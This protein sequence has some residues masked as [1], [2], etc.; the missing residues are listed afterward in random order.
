MNTHEIDHNSAETWDTLWEAEGY[1]SWR[2]E[3]LKEVYE[4]IGQL[5]P[6]HSKVIDIGG[7]IGI[8][9]RRLQE[10]GHSVEIWDRS[11][12][13][14]EMAQQ[15]GLQ[16]RVVDI[17]PDLPEI[18]PGTIVVATE[19]LEHLPESTRS[20]LLQKISGAG[21]KGLFSVPNNRLGPDE[22]PQHTI[23]YSAK[24]FRD[25][26]LKYFGGV[27]VEC[28]GTNFLL[29]VCG[30]KKAGTLSMCLPVRDEAGDL[31]VVLASF[32]GACDEIVV[33][34]DP[35]TKDRTRE[36]A[37][38]YAD[39]VFELENPEGPADQKMPNGG[40]H[41]AWIRNQCL[42]RCT[43][44]WI[45]MTEGHE[46]LAE[47]QDTLLALD[48]VPEHVKLA[49]VMR[50]ARGPV[51]RQE[52]L[53]PW[54]TRRTAGLRYKRHTHNILDI[55]DGTP[56]IFLPKVRT[57]HFRVHAREVARA[58][59]R[60]VQ[61]R[62]ELMRDWVIDE[63]VNSLYY[64]A[65]EWRDFDNSKS[66]DLFRELLVRDRKNGGRRYQ[67]GLILAKLLTERGDLKEARETLLECTGHDWN[68][69]EHWVFLGDLA[70][71]EE[72]YEE[73]KQFYLYAS[74]RIG[75]RPLTL[76]WIELSFY[77]FVPAQRLAMTCACLEQYEESL[78]WA[79][80]VLELLPEEAPEEM[81]GEAR[82]NIE[83]IRKFMEEE[84][85]AF[86]S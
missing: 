74:T 12:K 57:D 44:D 15:H 23:K 34:V 28:F 29:G 22:E 58:A 20:L 67:A 52:W 31:E 4:R 79:E 37:S 33:G 66:I 77:S 25:N 36:I 53:F 68:R 72:R 81:F 13:A 45:F 82:A 19:F 26:L 56:E 49:F 83:H 43:S 32:R 7:G 42:E 30:W 80:R 46:S 55:P 86:A 8:L 16:G 18:E 9:A 35:R 60:K 62:L 75:R 27:R 73:A 21:A 59:Q 70:F 65:S 64:L 5:L 78:G 10:L 50:S 6:T 39:V 1:N 51:G 24:S 84:G 3:V 40:V 63:N 2:G 76:W 48:Q 54:L 69:T 17:G 41:F 61:N 11:P 14:I 38:L 47:G 71:E 85:Y